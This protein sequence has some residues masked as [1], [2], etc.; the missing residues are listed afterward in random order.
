MINSKPSPTAGEAPSIEGELPGSRTQF[1]YKL[2]RILEDATKC[3]FDDVIAWMPC[4]KSFQVFSKKRFEEEVMIK[5]FDSQKYKTFQ[6]NLN[7]WGF[8]LGENKE[9][10]QEYFVRGRL[11]LCEQM[12]RVKMKGAYIRGTRSPRVI[13]EASRENDRHHQKAS[14]IEI[15][16]DCDRYIPAIVDSALDVPIPCYG[17]R[18]IWQ[19]R[20]CLNDG[21]GKPT[22]SFQSEQEY[23]LSLIE[24]GIQDAEHS[25]YSSLDKI[26]TSSDQQQHK[27]TQSAV[28]MSNIAAELHRLSN[29]SD[30]SPFP[31]NLKALL[32]NKEALAPLNL[33]LHTHVCRRRNSRKQQE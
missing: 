14:S 17:P 12:H 8:H 5:Y 19:A 16:K 23:L 10:A 18:A 22:R 32:S 4:G 21:Q 27:E 7:L 6:R 11:E 26:L 24:G 2:H 9:I 30:H 25:F 13:R 28:L 20:H 15:S 3:G 29:L 1:S 31:I 33:S